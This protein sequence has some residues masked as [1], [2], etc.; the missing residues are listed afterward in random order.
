MSPFLHSKPTLPQAAC[1]RRWLDPCMF[2]SWSLA[3]ACAFTSDTALAGLK[4]LPCLLCPLGWPGWRVDSDFPG[5]L[6]NPQEVPLA[7][8]RRSWGWVQKF[9]APVKLYVFMYILFFF[10]FFQNLSF[11]FSML[12][13]E[14]LISHMWEWSIAHPVPWGQPGLTVFEVPGWMLAVG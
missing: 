11:P 3:C 6:V 2:S 5:F 14:L 13:H 12:P 7:Q 8:I 10:F 9:Q 4:H 1:L